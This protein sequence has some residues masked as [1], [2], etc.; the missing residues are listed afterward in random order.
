[1]NEIIPAWLGLSHDVSICWGITLL[2]FLWQG[3]VIGLLALVA[4]RLLRSQSAS[5][6]YWLNAVALLACPICVACTFAVVDVPE[7]WQVNSNQQS[8][9]SLDS[10]GI[11]IQASSTDDLVDIPYPKLDPP[12]VVSNADAASASFDAAFNTPVI[13]PVVIDTTTSTRT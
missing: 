9:G 5:I 1:M 6:R 2:H 13:T 8:H 7:S 12:E 3:A 11:P 4:S 10:G